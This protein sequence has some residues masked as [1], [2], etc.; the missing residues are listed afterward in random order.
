MQVSLPSIVE[1]RI[2]LCLGVGC[3]PG[4]VVGEGLEHGRA[5]SMYGGAVYR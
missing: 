5:R 3:N 2:T 4:E 1:R